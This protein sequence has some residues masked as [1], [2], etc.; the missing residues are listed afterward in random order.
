MTNRDLAPVASPLPEVGRL[1]T[2]GRTW[3]ITR[4]L[5][6][7]T[8]REVWSHLRQRQ[9]WLKDPEIRDRRAAQRFLKTLVSLGPSF[10]KLG[11][12][13]STRPDLVPRVYIE[14]LSELQDRVPAMSWP[15]V[16]SILIQ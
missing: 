8:L 12:I 9:G 13:M 7:F 3:R 11:Q 15:E 16:E 1:E 10:I 14:E 5:G 2:L 4:D 6:L